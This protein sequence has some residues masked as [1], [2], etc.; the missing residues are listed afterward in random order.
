[1]S[2]SPVK[3]EILETLLL[4]EKP[5]K[6]IEI[7]KETQRKFQPVMGHLLG[8]IRSGYVNS[9][10]KGQFAITQKGKQALGIPET[11]K[12]MAEAILTYAPHDKA[13]SFYLALDKPL[14]IHAHTLRDFA[15]KLDKVELA[16]IEFHMER[17]D[18]EAWFSGIGDEE[19]AKKTILLR[20]KKVVGEDLRKQ[21][22]QVVEQRYLSLLKLSGQPVPVQQS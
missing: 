14:Y 20:Q 12:E 5:L 17:G 13:F 19:L 16:S 15:N 7:A 11:T 18:F 6:A 3:Q 2:L 8:L 9:L 21:L 10:E 22:R 1:M 4:C